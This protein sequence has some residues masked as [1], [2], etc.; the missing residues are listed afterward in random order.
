MSRKYINDKWCV[1]CGKT[2]PTPY[3]AKKLDVISPNPEARDRSVVVDIGCGNG[4][5]SNYMKEQGFKHVYSYDMAGD[6]GEEMVLG[7]DSFPLGAFSADIILANYIMMFLDVWEIAHT[8]REVNRIAK[9]GC[10]FVLELYGAKDSYYPTKEKI[11]SL[12]KEIE[13]LLEE[14]WEIVHSVQER[15]ILRKL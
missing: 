13:G 15:S 5:N 3:L 7:K 4:R 6:V 9:E 11:L 8:L 1:R 10:Y 2:A 12:Q 14:E